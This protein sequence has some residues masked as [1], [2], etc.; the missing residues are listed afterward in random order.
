MGKVRTMEHARLVKRVLE[1]PVVRP[2]GGHRRRQ[3]WLEKGRSLLTKLGLEEAFHALTGPKRLPAWRL[4]VEKTLKE[5]EAREWNSTLLKRADELHLYS[6]LKPAP[7]REEY[8]FGS[9]DGKYRP[10]PEGALAQLNMRGG[11]T[12]STDWHPPAHCRVCGNAASP[13]SPVHLLLECEGTRGPRQAA[14]EAMEKLFRPVESDHSIQAS[15]CACAM[16]D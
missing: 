5:H 9:E 1:A 13:E 2:G 11:W 14:M 10:D 8:L 6:Q 16:R 12:T 4:S 15:G 3:T 7:E